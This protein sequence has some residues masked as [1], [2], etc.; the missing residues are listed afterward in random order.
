M[1]TLLV[2]AVVA[3]TV[4]SAA[5]DHV[6]LREADAAHAMF[7]TATAAPRETLELSDVEAAAIENALGR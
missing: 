3:I 1:K 2:L 6:Y 5:A 7:P 4:R